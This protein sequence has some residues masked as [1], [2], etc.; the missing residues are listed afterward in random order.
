[1][2]RLIWA[3]FG[4]GAV[5]LVLPSALGVPGNAVLLWGNVFAGAAIMLISLWLLFGER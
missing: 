5:V 1:M 4:I 2:R 3:Q